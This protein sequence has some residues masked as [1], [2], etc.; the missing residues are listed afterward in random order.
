MNQDFTHFFDYLQKEQITIDKAEFE[1]QIKSHPDYPSLL[2]ISDTLSFFSID[3]LA[4]R[5]G[6]NQIDLLPERF[7][8]LLMEKSGDN[9]LNF[10]EKKG[11]NYSVT[12]EK[13]TKLISKQEL[14][15]RWAGIV[16]LAEKKDTEDI[17]KDN[18]KNYNRFLPVFVLVTFLTVLFYSNQ[19]L[20]TNLFFI[21][22]VL[23]ILFSIGALKELFDN[24]SKII[25]SFC[26]ITAST[27]CTEVVGSAKWKIFEII[28][29]SDLSIV[30]FV[31]Q[32]LGLFSFILNGNPE[33]YFSIQKIMLIVAIPVLF[34]SIYYQKIVEKKWCP[35][36]LLISCNIIFEFAYLFVFQKDNISFSFASV[37]LFGFIYLVV[38]FVW[39][40][41]KKLF[42]KQKELKEELSKSFRFERNYDVFKNSL[43]AKEKAQLPES[44]IILGNKESTTK[45]TVISNPYCSHCKGAHEVIE[46]ILEKYNDDV[47]IQVI[48]KADLESETKDSQK[49]FRSLM[50]IY[51][52]DGEATFKKALRN[53][54]EIKNTKE[55]FGL[56]PTD[57]TSEFDAIFGSQYK[58]CA[59][60]DYNFT[61]AIFI[62]GYE[63]PK[64][65]DRKSL[66]F[67]VGDLIDEEF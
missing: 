43:F 8:A 61:P 22:P 32:F 10:V 48:L 17:I 58:W 66:Q 14:V 37:I 59:E 16:L 55:W 41:L 34:L 39:N 31:S 25:S 44:P 3:N 64:M 26:N 49:L 13:I 29:F 65:Y 11:E 33:V 42:V 63:Y 52:E 23:G 54:F 47:Q 24:K 53:W 30:F 57:A 35:I 4:T 21:F 18:K 15:D 20:R 28:N 45:I 46:T 9:E 38:L 12:K 27:S 62:N 19:D 5:L 7:M 60:N 36:C 67:F 40:N 1:F 6:S 2:A 56:F 51:Q 50:K